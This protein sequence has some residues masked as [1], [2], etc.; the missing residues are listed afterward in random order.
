MIRLGLVNACNHWNTVI[1]PTRKSP[2]LTHALFSCSQLSKADA[3]LAR[4]M[5]CGGSK[6]SE[7][8][9]EE[10]EA[11]DKE[12]KALDFND[13]D[14]K[15][16]KILVVGTPESGKRTFGKQI[17]ILFQDGYSEAERKEFT[18][19]IASNVYRNAK[20]LVDGADKLGIASSGMKVCAAMP[21]RMSRR[22]FL[23]FRRELTA[24]CLVIARVSSPRCALSSPA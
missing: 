10:M 6:P 19:S 2:A 8:T 14:A 15:T 23:G 1:D 20:A 24:V 12:K 18:T 5:G 17:K 3:P 11:E 16:V 4:V 9:P 21:P 22:R 7:K 13:Q